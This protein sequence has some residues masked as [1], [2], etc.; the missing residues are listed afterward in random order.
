MTGDEAPGASRLKAAFGHLLSDFR[1]EDATTPNGLLLAEEKLVAAVTR[2]EL[3]IVSDLDW[4]KEDDLKKLK[5][6]EQYHVRS[7]VLQCLAL[8]RDPKAPLHEKG[9]QL[10]GAFL[11]SDLDLEDAQLPGPLWLHH[12]YFD[13]SVILRHSRTRTVSL[14]GS[15]IA[16]LEGD[17]AEVAGEVNLRHGFKAEKAVRLIGAEIGGDLDCSRGTFQNNGGVTLHCDGAE[18]M[19]GVFLRDGFKSEGEVRLYSAKIGTNLD[20]SGGTFQNKGGNALSCD[21][22]K[23]CVPQQGF[24][25]RWRGAPFGRGGRQQPR[26]HQRF[27]PEQGRDRALLRRRKGRGCALFA[28]RLQGRGPDWFGGGTRREPCRR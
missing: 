15:R 4:T 27:V 17:G 7:E 5:E 23:D 22:V 9:I 6:E 24:Q 26:M 10:K 20:C 14:G 11:P 16:G 12:C 28:P 25:G 21:R 19:G 13:G 18:I 1:I 3:C 2:G 8:G